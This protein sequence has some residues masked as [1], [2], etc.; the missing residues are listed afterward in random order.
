MPNKP[1]LRV[2]EC[3]SLENS[4][5]ANLHVQKEVQSS[6]Q[7]QTGR[8]CGYSRTLWFLCRAIGAHQAAHVQ[9]KQKVADQVGSFVGNCPVRRNTDGARTSRREITVNYT[10]PPHSPYIIHISTIWK[11]LVRHP[12]SVWLP[13]QKHYIQADITKCVH[14]QRRNHQRNCPQRIRNRR[15]G[16][17]HGFSHSISVFARWFLS[18]SRAYFKLIAS[19]NW[20]CRPTSTVY[21]PHPK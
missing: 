20:P 11:C 10:S 12:I 18:H 3:Q 5:R 15:S 1:F 7:C 21:A 16:T 6:D 17:N 19:H 13:Y 4:R 9:I 2:G 8:L 14:C